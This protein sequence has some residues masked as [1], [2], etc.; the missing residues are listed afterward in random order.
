MLSGLQ[1]GAE[2][3]FTK[4]VDF[5]LLMAKVVGCVTRIENERRVGQ[6]L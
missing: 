4:P 2:A 3:Y 5:D 6:G 1:A